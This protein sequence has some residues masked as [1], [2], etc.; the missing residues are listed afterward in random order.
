MVG[1]AVWKDNGRMEGRRRPRGG[2]MKAEGRGKKER[3]SG[4]GGAEVGCGRSGG[5]VREKR[6]LCIEE[7]EGCVRKE[8]FLA[9][10]ANKFDFSA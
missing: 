9:K 8:G 4:V 7:A 6:R 5:R 3:R 10:N 1:V 2:R